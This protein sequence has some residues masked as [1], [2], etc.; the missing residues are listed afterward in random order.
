[1]YL[2]FKRKIHYFDAPGERTSCGASCSEL[3]SHLCCPGLRALRG[4]SHPSAVLLPVMGRLTLGGQAAFPVAC[5]VGD[6]GGWRPRKGKARLFLPYP[7][8]LGFWQWPFPLAGQTCWSSSLCLLVLLLPLARPCRGWQFPAVLISACLTALS[9]GLAL[10]LYQC[11]QFS[12]LRFICLKYIV[13]F[14]FSQSDRH[15]HTT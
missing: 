2:S 3:Y 7:P 5:S 15:Q 13:W 4:V 1:M 10:F 6:T 9:F 11:R 12:V 14:L 8:C